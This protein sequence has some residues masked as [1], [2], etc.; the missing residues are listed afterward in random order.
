VIDRRARYFGPFPN[1]W[2]QGDDQQLQ[3]AFRLRTCEDSV[4]S[5]RSRPAVASD[6]PVQRPCV[7]LISG[8]HYGQ[9][10]ERAVRFLNGAGGDVV[11]EL[12]QRMNEAPR[13]SVT[14]RRPSSGTGWPRSPRCTASVDIALRH[15]LDDRRDCG[16]RGTT[17]GVNLGDDRA[18]VTWRSP[19]ST[20][21]P[22]SPIRRS[23][24]GVHVAALREQQCPRDRGQPSLSRRL[25]VTELRGRLV[26]PL[27]Q[28]C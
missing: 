10:V 27:L 19:Y 16:H 13:S 3:K 15:E 12:E 2:R 5:H 9:D 24:R 20:T 28:L 14:K 8:E 1:A 22:S 4:F 11:A 21:G 17:T 6:W 23:A 18:A 7:G 26:H 25:F